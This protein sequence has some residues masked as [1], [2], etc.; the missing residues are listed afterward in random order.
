MTKSMTGQIDSLE[1]GLKSYTQALVE[2]SQINL[3]GEIDNL[4]QK[5]QENRMEN[6]RCALDLKNAAG[7]LKTEKELLS[8]IKNEIYSQFDITTSSFKD[9]HKGTNENF[10]KMKEEYDLIKKKFTEIAE[11]VKVYNWLILGCKIQEELRS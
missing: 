3:K 5:I 7:E 6:H 1:K 9:M 4:I 2:T 11:F 10:E 8:N